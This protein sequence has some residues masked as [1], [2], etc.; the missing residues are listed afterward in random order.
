MYKLTRPD[1]Y[2]FYSGTINYRE[3]IGT[4]IR[5]T[6]YDPP[7]KGSCGRGLH[8]SKNPNNCFVGTRIP[9]AAFRVRG[10]Q[11]IAKD[12]YKT[13]YQALK[14][15]EEITNLDT[16][17]GWKYS[18]AINPIHPF[19]IVPPEINE[20]HIELIKQWASVWDSVRASVGASVRDSVWASVWASVGDS[21]WD[22]V[23]ASVGASVRDSVWA[24]VRA[25][26]RAYTGSLFPNIKKWEY[27]NHKKGE[28]P[29]QP[30]VDL[31]K[32]GLVPSFD[33][34]TWR[35]HGKEDAEILLEIS[36]GSLV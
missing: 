21:V 31:W 15:V 5:V 27:I 12:S 7:E 26:V 35:L 19:K 8:A 14:V 25:S 22:S 2:D 18:E 11:L 32:Q 36:S 23:R 13:R 3:A 34:K 24:S 30:V 28:Y 1:G 4:I 16:L 33:G 20:G 9:C 29:L 10:I 17:F 6:D